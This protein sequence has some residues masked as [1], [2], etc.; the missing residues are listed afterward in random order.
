VAILIQF[1]VYWLLDYKI[2]TEWGCFQCTMYYV[3]FAGQN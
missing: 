2:L 1:G 3:L